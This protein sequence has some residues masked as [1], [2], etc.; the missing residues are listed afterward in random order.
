[1]RNTRA[2][3]VAGAIIK[4]IAR[5]SFALP[6]QDSLPAWLDEQQIP[7]MIGADTRAI[8]IA[9]REH[10]TIWAALAVGEA[11][12]LRAE[13]ELAA[14]VRTATTTALVPSVAAR[15]RHVEG[16]RGGP[17]VTLIDCGV[18]RAILRELTALGSEV[19]VV[20]Y[21]ATQEELLEGDP[22]A[23][24]ISPGPGDPTDLQRDDRNVARSDRTQ[25]DVRRVSGPSVTRPCM[26]RDDV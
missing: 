7:A 8:T 3:C 11:A 12:I 22:D 2:A 17:R 16:T 21:N 10:G 18:K 23:I 24:F 9:L 5:A 25:A 20:P 14:F 19:T 26:R 4:E 13:A 6:E 15:E 1:M